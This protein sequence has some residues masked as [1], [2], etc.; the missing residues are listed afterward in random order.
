MKTKPGRAR[1]EL[2]YFC[3]W[4]LWFIVDITIWLVVY[5][6]L[7]KIWKSVGRI[8]PYTMEKWLK[9]P[10]RNNS[11]N[12]SPNWDEITKNPYIHPLPS[13][14]TSQP[15]VIGLSLPNENR[16]FLKPSSPIS[17]DWFNEKFTGKPQFFNGK[18]HGF[19]FRFSLKPISI[20]NIF[21]GSTNSLV[22]HQSTR[23]CYFVA[24]NHPYLWYLKLQ[25]PLW[26]MVFIAIQR[27]N[28]PGNFHD[29]Y[30]FNYRFHQEKGV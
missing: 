3:S 4:I 22:L 12:H 18:I 24:T 25:N 16:P 6:P 21:F 28:R 14:N 11:W 5:L 9:P 1:V 2:P 17:M 30:G 7:W 15:R 8:I 20:D 26:L 13:F 27:P 23:L 29:S 19:R 10:T